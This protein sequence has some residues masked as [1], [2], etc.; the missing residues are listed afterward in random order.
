[1]SWRKPLALARNADRSASTP[2]PT[3]VVAPQPAMATAGN[4]VMGVSRIQRYFPGGD[5]LAF[6]GDGAGNHEHRAEA[7]SLADFDV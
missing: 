5:G 7:F 4:E 1:M 6:A 2:Q 3:A